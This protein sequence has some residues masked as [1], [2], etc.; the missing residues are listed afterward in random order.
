[1]GDRDEF[2]RKITAV[3][4]NNWTVRHFVHLSLKVWTNVSKL[5]LLLAYILLFS[6][7]YVELCEQKK[8]TVLTINVPVVFMA[9]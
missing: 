3:I 2:I 8:K 5:Y 6:Y 1:M 7:S 4:R 9:R